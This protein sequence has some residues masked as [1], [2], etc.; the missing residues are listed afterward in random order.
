M[1]VAD[2]TLIYW[3]NYDHQ[4]YAIAQ[5]PTDTAVSIQ[6][7]VVTLGDTVLVTGSVVDISAGTE[8]EEQA[9]RFPDGV[10]AVSEDSMEGW[11]EYVYMQKARPSD[12]VGV[13]VTLTVLDP[14]NN[15][16]DV[17]TA[18]SDASGMFSL[19]FEPEVPG[20]YTVIATFPGSAGYW[21][22][23]SETAIIVEEA[24]LP[25]APEEPLELPPTETYITAATIAI[26]IAI[27]IV[28][29][30]LFRKR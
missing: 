18:T 19:T 10:P 24:P 7:D 2:G 8:Q 20:K 5:G 17:G 16:Y 6:N 13:D 30:L 28:G 26:I 14:N 1:S 22:S 23:Y 25:P 4:I 9:R 12:T 27:A 11:M 29:L 3:N 15:V 21:G